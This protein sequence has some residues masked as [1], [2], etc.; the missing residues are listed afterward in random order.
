[1]VLGETL[2]QLSPPGST[3]LLEV[4]VNGNNSNELYLKVFYIGET[5]NLPFNIRQL[6]LSPCLTDPTQSKCLLRNLFSIL[7]P[8]LNVNWLLQCGFDSTFNLIQAVE[9]SLDRS[10]F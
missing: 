10:L 4:H 8:L 5:S 3:I 1:M 9:D 6:R 7:Q 2:T